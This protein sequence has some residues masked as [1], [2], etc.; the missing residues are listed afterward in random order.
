MASTGQTAAH[1]PHWVQCLISYLP[2]A[3]KC[4]SIAK[5]PILGLFSPNTD[6]EHASWHTLHPEQ[7]ACLA[8]SFIKYASPA[9]S[10][11]GTT[12]ATN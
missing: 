5:R 7:S 12:I 2:G 8:A 4:A 9:N 10:N 11:V 3:G 6:S 1:S